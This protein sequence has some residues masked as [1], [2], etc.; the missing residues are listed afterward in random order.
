MAGCIEHN[1]ELNEIYE[2]YPEC[3]WCAENVGKI[4]LWG[5]LG[6]FVL[7]LVSGT[8]G[9][10]Q[11]VIADAIHSA[12]DVALAAILMIC[13]RVSK[14]P[15]DEKHPYGYGNVEYIASLFVGIS[16]STVATLILYTAIA[17]LRSGVMHQPNIVAT[18]GLII[19]IVGNELMFRHSLCC[20]QRF[21]SPAMIANAWENRADVYSTLAALVGVVGAQLGLLFMDPVGA[22]L[23]AI[24]LVYSA[25]QMLRD[26][27]HGILDHSLNDCMQ[28]R[29]H[30]LALSDSNVK[31][32]VSLQTRGIGQYLGID[33]KLAVSPHLTLE[34][35]YALCERIK[36]QLKDEFN[37]LA[38]ITVSP[39]G[40]D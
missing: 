4:S 17:D 10:S 39:V 35:G 36:Q 19:S 13:L 2:I 31:G 1:A 38:L 14:L 11:A 16:L 12:A 7:K 32:I 26:A 6:L 30:D 29:I 18:L 15:P 40:K 3:Y 25:F 24:L 33:L 23:V 27:W 37:R 28:E 9:D 34:E 5:N 22:I 8:A 21:G 20:G